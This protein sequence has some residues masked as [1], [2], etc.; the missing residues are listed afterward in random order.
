VLLGLAP[1]AVSIVS[2]IFG[3]V[4]TY[5]P[6]LGCE[7]CPDGFGWFGIIVLMAFGIPGVVVLLQGIT[8]LSVARGLDASRPDEQVVETSGRIYSSGPVDAPQAAKRGVSI[9]TF[10]LGL[11]LV[12]TGVVLISLEVAGSPPLSVS[13]GGVLAILFGVSL[14][15]E[16]AV[17]V[18]PRCASL[19][20]RFSSRVG[21]IIGGSIGLLIVIFLFGTDPWSLLLWGPYIFPPAI[22]GLIIWLIVKPKSRR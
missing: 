4:T 14:S 22:I 20:Q 7:S 19:V 8:M 12:I 3:A 21:W 13:L 11:F 15:V 2:W 17:R 5:V 1:F 18:S 10:V 9:A 16:G 6:Q